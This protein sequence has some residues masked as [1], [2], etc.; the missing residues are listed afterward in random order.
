MIDCREL[1]FSPRLC[2]ERVARAQ[3]LLGKSVI[4]RLIAWVLFLLGGRRSEIAAALEMPEG[5]LRTTLRRL[6]TEGLWGLLDRRRKDIGLPPPAT[7]DVPHESV[8]LSDD[9]ETLFL[10][11]AETK[12]PMENKDQRRVVLLSLM[13]KGMLSANCVAKALGVTP[14]H[15]RKLKQALQDGDVAAVLDKRAGQVKDY[16]VDEQAKA[17]LIEQFVVDLVTRG[18]TSASAVARRMGDVYDRPLPERTVRS[19]LHKLG[20]ASIK[21]SLLTQLRAEKRNP[22]N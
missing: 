17:Q 11:E 20:L 8:R 7:P 6:R 1:D 14:G 19:H 9:G 15:A 13:G 3:V 4:S 22:R 12:L 2:S 10:G 16:R 21:E 18:R 5:T